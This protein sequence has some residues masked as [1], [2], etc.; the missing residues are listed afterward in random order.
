MLELLVKRGLLEIADEASQA[1]TR[2]TGHVVATGP[3]ASLPDSIAVRL[4]LPGWRWRCRATSSVCGFSL[5]ELVVV[6]AIGSLLF[7]V[8]TLHVTAFLHREKVLSSARLLES[9]M[10]STRLAAIRS[11]APAYAAV[12]SAA[13]VAE[14]F[15]D[16][17]RDGTMSWTEEL[18]AR[19]HLPTPLTFEGPDGQP[20]DG[21]LLADEQHRL[22]FE[23]DGS[24]GNT[25]SIRLSDGRGNYFEVRVAPRATARTSLRMLQPEQAPGADGSRW[26]AR[27]EIPGGWTWM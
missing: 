26:F 24:V 7:L 22:R 1:T 11:R 4:R 25:G 21:L 15:V 2:T 9:A 10:R 16:I 12:D 27:D 14:F 18:V 3:S 17:D 19:V 20:G 5:I 23:P 8:G 6:L 13:R